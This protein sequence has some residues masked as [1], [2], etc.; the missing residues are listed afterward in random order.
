MAM[1]SLLVKAVALVDQMIVGVGKLFE[2]PPTIRGRGN[3]KLAKGLKAR[4]VAKT[5]IERKTAT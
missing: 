1:R 4:R 3:V 2:P 5:I